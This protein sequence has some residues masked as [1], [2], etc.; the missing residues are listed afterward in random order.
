MMKE[1]TG[2][3]RSYEV[4]DKLRIGLT[5]ASEMSLL[6][7]GLV[8]NHGVIFP[9]KAYEDTVCRGSE[10]FTGY[11]DYEFEDVETY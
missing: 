8:T 10:C 6:F 5:V 2:T 11:Y 3:W 1:T 7:G 9:Y 4:K